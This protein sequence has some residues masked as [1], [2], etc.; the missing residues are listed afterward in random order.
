MRVVFKLERKRTFS[1]SNGTK[2]WRKLG[3]LHRLTGPA[4]EYPSGRAEWWV[5]GFGIYFE[6]WVRL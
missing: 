5:D 4:Y 6:R 1:I 2:Y 3:K